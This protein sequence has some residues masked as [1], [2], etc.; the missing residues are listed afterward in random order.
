LKYRQNP[1]NSSSAD[2]HAIALGLKQNHL[3]TKMILRAALFCAFTLVIIY[4][5][6]AFAQGQGQ[7]QSQN[8]PDYVPGEYLIKLKGRATSSSSTGALQKIAGK[9]SFKASYAALNIH[10]IAFKANA[11]SPEAIEELKNDPAVEYIEPNYILR[12]VEIEGEDRMVQPMAAAREDLVS[13]MAGSPG[14]YRQS[15]AQISMTQAWQAASADS[16]QIDRPIVAIIDSGL[17]FDHEVFRSS[18]HAEGVWINSGEIANNNLDDDGNG[19]IDDVV[20]YDFLNNTGHVIDDDGHGTHVAGIVMGASIDIFQMPIQKS[21]IRIMALKFLGADGAGTT[22]TAIRA[23][24]YAVNNGAQVINNSWGGPSYSA[25]LHE[26]LTNAY[27]HGVVLVSAAGNYGKNNDVQPMY[28]A[29]FDIPSNIAVGASNDWDSLASFSNY[30][31]GSVHIAAPGVS[32]KSTLPGSTSGYMSGTSMAAPLVAGIA[33]MVVRESPDMSGFQV[34][35]VLLDSADNIDNIAAKISSGR[36]VNPYEAIL[37]ARSQAQ[38]AAFQP[39]YSPVYQ[40]ESRSVASETPKSEAAGCGMVAELAKK[41][42]GHGGE[43]PNVGLLLG[44]LAL[45]LVVLHALRAR[46]QAGASRRRFERFAMSSDIK[47]NVG[48]KELT[49]HMKT[50]SEGGLSFNAETMLEQGGIITMQIA[51][52]DGK[53]VLEVQGKVVWSEANRAYGVQFDE[54]QGLIKGWTKGLTKA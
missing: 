36:R 18:S 26:A 46:S 31:I 52:P 6:S 7:A 30:G 21:K 32:I 19:Y 39:D 9:A 51:S 48:G 12:K 33:A 11:N 27:N 41:G 8:K 50:I 5:P 54:A 22:A 45:P 35:E 20:G 13:A 40:Q 49:G 53:Q 17:D 47:V 14:S 16:S 2:A 25:A 23:I 42:P 1:Y 28:P 10:H 37:S 15:G 29:G 44:F 3:Q 4:L 43:S 38:T 24:N 34:K